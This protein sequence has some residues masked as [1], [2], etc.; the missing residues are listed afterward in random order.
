M[1][2]GTKVA[3]SDERSISRRVGLTVSA[4]AIAAVLAIP[5]ATMA[6]KG[7]TTAPASIR[8]NQPAGA[9]AA[10]GLHLGDAVTF[11]TVVSGLKGGEWAMVL[12]ECYA[13]AGGAKLYAQLD[14][15]SASFVLGGGSS[16]WW[17]AP[18]DANCIGYLEAYGGRSKGMDTIRRLA[19]TDW[20]AVAGS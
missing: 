1:A 6:A 19:W 5:A 16:P 11:T 4:I 20:F 13:T 18:Q 14:Y 8:L 2:A 3:S 15:P 17:R 12:V 10:A 7:G 9:V